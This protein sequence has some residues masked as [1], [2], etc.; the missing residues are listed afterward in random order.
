MAGVS[1]ASGIAEGSRPSHDYCERLLKIY[2]SMREGRGKQKKDVLLSHVPEWAH[3]LAEEPTSEEKDALAARCID[4]TRAPTFDIKVLEGN[5]RLQA[6]L[7]NCTAYTPNKWLVEKEMTKRRSNASNEPDEDWV[8]TWDADK[9]VSWRT[10]EGEQKT[11][12][13]D[14]Y[15]VVAQERL[16]GLA[17]SGGGIRSATFSLGILQALAREGLLHRFD[18]LS[19]V[20]GGGYIHQWLAAWIRREPHGIASV[21]RK[22][23]PQP[24][25]GS[26]ARAPEQINWLRR[27]S[28]YLTPSKGLFT[29]DTWTMIAIWFRNTFLNQVVL[30]SFFFVC[31]GLARALT[32]PFSV[33][34]PESR[35]LMSALIAVPAVW[36]LCGAWVFGRALHSQTKPPGEGGTPP[37]GAIGNLAVI[38]WVVLPAFLFAYVLALVTGAWVGPPIDPLMWED[39]L[40]G[41]WGFCI[42]VLLLV[43]TFAGEAPETAEQN[44]PAKGRTGHKAAVGFGVTAVLCVLVPVWVVAFV[45]GRGDPISIAQSAADHINVHLPQNAVCPKGSAPSA[46]A[47][48]TK[49]VC[50]VVAAP[51]P[52]HGISSH[53]VVAIF[54]P[55]IF[56][57]VQFL[58]VRLQLGLIGRPYE[59]SR[60]EWLARLGG[61]AAM[62]GFLWLG[63]AAIA[64]VGPSLFYALF[65]TSFERGLMSVLAVIVTHAVTL[66]AGSSSK[67]SGA[68]DPRK[69]FGFG[70]MD[71]VGMIGAPIAIVA[72]LVIA[73]GFVDLV[74]HHIHTGLLPTSGF[75][76]VLGCFIAFFLVAGGFFGWRVDINEFSLH[77]F[78]RNRLARCYL[79]ASNG[80]RV[81]DPFTGF[82]DHEETSSSAGMTLAELLPERFKGFECRGKYDGPMPIF[83]STVNLTSGADLAYQD[84]KG[85][86]FAFTPLYSGYHVNWTTERGDDGQ[87]TYNGFVPTGEYAYRHNCVL[88]EGVSGPCC[89]RR[90]GILLAS[91]A[92]I[93]GAALSP[94]QGYNSQPALAFLM[95]L[96]NV[97]LGWWI[98]NTRKPEVWPNIPQTTARQ[99]RISEAFKRRWPKMP[100]AMPEWIGWLVAKIRPAGQSP[101]PRFGLLK[102]I[103]ELCG[104]SDDATEYVCLSDGGQFDNMGLY[105]LIRRRVSL[106]V[107]CDGEEDDKTTFEGM[108]MA[109]AKARIDF[110]VD[111]HFDETEIDKLVP[112]VAA[113][114]PEEGPRSKV[115]FIVG[116]IRYPP[117]PESQGG[118]K[119]FTGTILYLKTAFVGDEPLDLRHYKREHPEFPQEGTMNQWF[120]EAQFES[121]RRLG[122]LT[123][124]LAAARLRG[125][126]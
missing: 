74:L 123:G 111:I 56:F 47:A 6:A 28:S 82:D 68:P 19:S 99:R 126:L 11:A 33:A 91:V 115:H 32:H 75:A 100:A 86:S 30:F 44:K 41:V 22:M 112:R 102:L 104:S 13:V 42:L 40:F 58:C 121:Y 61:W 118:Q 31:L 9:T 78:Y 107:V 49:P 72:L 71:V 4:E 113:D 90:T 3:E 92:A 21:E 55:L 24:E 110:G 70:L 8:A 122:Q 66:Y 80:R 64:R 37:P 16:S 12:L 5:P 52:Q 114:A 85:A 10:L 73:S 29:A 87:T 7:A 93:S 95:T 27:Y 89:A 76:T 35:L 101:S 62:V 34:L 116:E 23:S 51:N 53:T 18:Y 14:V 106:I 96:F 17:L 119:K 97:R 79:G 98:A 77:P 48:M 109:I 120:T 108:G 39:V 50:T 57:G 69:F 103:A 38:G 54:L 2:E 15:D 81:P 36:S 25:D 65:D 124:E 43:Q 94:N 125:V 46:D 67:T 83:C 84:R 60:R 117:P 20:S 59:D 63:L 45:A 105:E 1:G 26:L 88:E